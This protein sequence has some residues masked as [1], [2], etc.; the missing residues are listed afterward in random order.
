MRN[1]TRDAVKT[2]APGTRSQRGA[3]H[4]HRVSPTVRPVSTDTTVLPP[5]PDNHQSS[6]TAPRMDTVNWLRSLVPYA[7][8]HR[9]IGGVAPA[10]PPPGRT[11]PMRH[12]PRA[13][14]GRPVACGR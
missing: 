12:C 4:V 1:A 5:A 8:E 3:V 2:V 11:G 10:E 9:P 13:R 7:G 6:G 14:A